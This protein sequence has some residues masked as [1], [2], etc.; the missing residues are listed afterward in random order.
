MVT[1][2]DER[3]A[4]LCRWME[5][6][7]TDVISAHAKM[8]L[9][10][11]IP[12]E[13]LVDM[14]E[15]LRELQRLRAAPAPDAADIEELLRKYALEIRRAC[16][17]GMTD[18]YDDEARYKQQAMIRRD[19]IIAAFAAAVQRGREEVAAWHEAENEWLQTLGEAADG[20]IGIALLNRAG[21]HAAAA[22]HI[23]HI[24]GAGHG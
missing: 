2:S 5:I 12:A 23:R 14:A 3:L 21:E 4:D 20:K 1:I 17:A 10:D 24:M 18:A 7:S 19:H 11:D 15:A 22:F 6:A 9:L 13:D 8:A 16:N